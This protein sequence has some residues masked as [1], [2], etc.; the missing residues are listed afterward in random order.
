MTDLSISLTFLQI[1]VSESQKELSAS[2]PS[3]LWEYKKLNG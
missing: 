3:P 2:Y 1:C